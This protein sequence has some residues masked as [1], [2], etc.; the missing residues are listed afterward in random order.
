MQNVMGRRPFLRSA[1]GILALPALNLFAE[2]PVF[3]AKTTAKRMVFMSF[4]WGV[5]EDTWYPAADDTG[6]TYALPEGLQGRIHDDESFDR[7]FDAFQRSPCRKPRITMPR[8]I[9]T[10]SRIFK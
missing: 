7:P 4:G 1:T 3:A 2:S 5:T 9:P 8:A 10:L 6:A